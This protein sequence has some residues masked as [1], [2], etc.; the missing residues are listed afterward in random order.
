M[1][2]WSDHKN[3]IGLMNFS[4]GGASLY[5]MLAR[6]LVDG[7]TEAQVKAKVKARLFKPYRIQVSVQYRPDQDCVGLSVWNWTEIKGDAAANCPALLALA[8]AN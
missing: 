3:T 1:C 2:D 5:K 8:N 6:E 4:K 7:K